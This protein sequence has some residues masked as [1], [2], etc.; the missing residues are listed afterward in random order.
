MKPSGDLSYR[1]SSPTRVYLVTSELKLRPPSVAAKGH[2]AKGL[3]SPDDEAVRRPE[4][5]RLKPD[6]VYLV[7]SELKR[8]PLKNGLLDQR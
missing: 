5:Q 7:T 3:R 4:L 2:E 1:G 6:S 8:H